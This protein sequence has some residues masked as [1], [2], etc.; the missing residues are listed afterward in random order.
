MRFFLYI[1]QYPYCQRLRVIRIKIKCI[2]NLIT[3]YLICH[4]L[5]ITYLINDNPKFILAHS[6]IWLKCFNEFKIYQ[7]NIDK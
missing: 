7:S 3:P 4:C 2:Q 6:F 5:R 1:F